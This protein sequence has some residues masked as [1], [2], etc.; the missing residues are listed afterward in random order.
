MPVVRHDEG[1]VHEFHGSRFT[2]Y[3]APSTGS[4]ELCAWRLDVAAHSRGVPHR[5]TRDEVI[6]LLAGA[7][8]VSLEGERAEI[9]PGDVVIVPAGTELGVDGGPVPATA[10]V[11]T[12]PGLRAVTPDGWLTPPWTR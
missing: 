11:T 2:S 1:T 10:W 6:A 8:T 7:I 5:I 4:P 3:A 12:T 9:H